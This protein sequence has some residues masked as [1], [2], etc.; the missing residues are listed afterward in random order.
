MS[1]SIEAENFKTAIERMGRNTKTAYDTLVA[2]LDAVDT[3]HL[4][5]YYKVGTT[6]NTIE[7]DP[8]TYDDD[9]YQL[10][11]A[12]L[13]EERRQTAK[14]A[15][16]FARIVPADEFA[17]MV[18]MRDPV[19]GYRICWGHV[20]GLLSLDSAAQRKK[21]YKKIVQHRLTAKAFTKQLRE[22]D[23]DRKVATGGRPHRKPGTLELCISQIEDHF[24]QCDAKY[25][26]VWG[27]VPEGVEDT[28]VL[29]DMRDI[30]DDN[31]TKDL[32]DR[33]RE[34]CDQC[35]KMETMLAHIKTEADYARDRYYTILYT[36]GEIDADEDDEDDEDE[37][38]S[39]TLP[40]S[41]KARAV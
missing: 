8:G 4:A 9:G 41:G 19:T 27:A 22:S 14:R 38:G 13:L 32:L 30:Q 21:W 11:I 1:K 3:G 34:L 39:V 35:E 33:V 15:Q 6:L 12:A 17:Q 36:R 24:A 20:P 26:T 29:V 25:R 28:S 10:I 18:E 2:D 7:D 23:P 40:M 5:T 37:V 16:S 31:I